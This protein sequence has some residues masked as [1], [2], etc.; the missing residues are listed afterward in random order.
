MMLGLQSADAVNALGLERGEYLAIRYDGAVETV[1]ELM[2]RARGL[3][4]RMQ[5]RVQVLSVNQGRL[6]NDHLRDFSTSNDPL[7]M[8]FSVLSSNVVRFS[9][10]VRDICSREAFSLG[11]ISDC[12]TGAVYI[13]CSACSEMSSWAGLYAA[14]KELALA[15]NANWVVERMPDAWRSLRTPV[16]HPEGQD[17]ELMRG[18]KRTLDPSNIFNPGRFV[19]GI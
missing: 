6:L 9:D 18:I 1:E 7:C 8:R 5:G 17:I 12:R 10:A 4:Q 19:G 11:M 14:L 13:N 15:F 2:G 16:W 3:L